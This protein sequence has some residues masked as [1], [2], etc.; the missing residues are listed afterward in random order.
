MIHAIALR[1]AAIQKM[2]SFFLCCYN[3]YYLF[4]RFCSSAIFNSFV[5][6][7]ASIVRATGSVAIFIFYES[8]E[9][10]SATKGETE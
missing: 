10:E 8:T 9:P 4:R 7:Y 3:I 2:N 5:C 1:T 6:R